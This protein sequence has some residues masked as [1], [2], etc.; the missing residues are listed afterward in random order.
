VAP[1]A[2]PKRFCAAAAADD[3]PKAKAVEPKANGALVPPG[4][5]LE[6]SAGNIAAPA[7]G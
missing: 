4:A 6:A 1:G 5:A 7:L 2:A 3:A